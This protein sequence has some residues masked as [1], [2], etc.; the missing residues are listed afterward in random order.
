DN[1]TTGHNMLDDGSAGGHVTLID[2]AGNDT[3]VV[4][5]TLD[6]VSEAVA[7]ST[8]AAVQSSVNFNL[9]TQGAHINILTLEGSGNLT[10][11]GAAPGGDLITGNTGNDILDDNGG[12]AADSLIG[13]STGGHDTFI[14]SNV[15][16]QV[17]ETTSATTALVQSSVNFSLAG[18]GVNHLTLTGTGN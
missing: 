15:G 4:N 1:T 6:T 8:S 14:V 10:G 9:Q 16:D 3:F 13:N 18:T 2:N 5:S 7:G 11:K 12:T 17:S